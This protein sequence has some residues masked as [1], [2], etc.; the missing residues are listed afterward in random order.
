MITILQKYK[1]NNE[2][3]SKIESLEK[4]LKASY[5]DIIEQFESKKKELVALKNNL[6]HENHD[7]AEKNFIFS[8]G[9][10]I[11]EIRRVAKEHGYSEPIVEV[12]VSTTVW[13]SSR[14]PVAKSV[15]GCRKWLESP[16][17]L[18]YLNKSYISV[19]VERDNYN[20]RDDD[21]FEFIYRKGLDFDMVLTDGSKLEDNLRTEVDY[22]DFQGEYHTDLL[23]KNNNSKNLIPIVIDPTN[24]C[25]AFY[26]HKFY[27]NDIVFEALYNLMYEREK[28][29]ENS[30]DM[31][32]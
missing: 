14:T 23:F 26:N 18:I 1:D 12:K 25:L 22:D 28:A 6:K 3:I 17:H 29:E 27:S 16:E 20:D 15:R 19:K 11:N 9:E 5:D 10:V 8:S 21:Y 32:K 13:N 2:K 30:E 31:E 7:I 4:E 24:E